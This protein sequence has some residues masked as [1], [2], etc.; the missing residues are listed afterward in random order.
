MKK[1]LIFAGIIFLVATGLII[2]ALA[3][4][5]NTSSTQ[6]PNSNQ[7]N[8]DNQSPSTSNTG[9]TTGLDLKYPEELSI[10]TFAKNLDGPRDLLI[11]PHDQLLVSL[12]SKGQVV[13]F[14]NNDSDGASDRTLPIA[15]GLNRPH[16]LAFTNNKLYVA[17]TDKVSIFDY[18]PGDAQA[19]NKKVLFELPSGGNHWTRSLLIKG[20]K[21]YTSTG[22]TC[23]V[24]NESDLRRASVMVSSLDGSNLRTFASGL[25]NSV[26]LTIH[27]QSGKIWATEMG[28]DL[29]GDNLPPDEINILEDGN[30]YGW[31]YCYGKNIHD[32]KFDAAKYSSPTPCEY[33]NKTI[34]HIDLPAHSAPLGLAFIPSSWPST[35]QGQLLIAYHGSWNRSVPTGYKISL[36]NIDLAGEKVGE[37]D[38]ISG[39]LTGNKKLGRP[40]DLEFNSKGTLYISDDQS[41]TIYSVTAPTSSSPNP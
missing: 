23:N 29:L 25:R 31:P 16:G 2:G 40:V 13:T 5:T 17:E 24:C 15:S 12:P 4:K 19:S 41:G 37:S 10:S 14:V 26:F 20:D 8:L 21:L 6:S 3:K 35:Y 32:K 38:F 22:S 28:R 36:I 39:W 33:L 11:L 9:N 34:S 18:A 1:P 7:A 30:D 27:P